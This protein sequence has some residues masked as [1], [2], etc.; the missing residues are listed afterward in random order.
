MRFKIIMKKL[1]NQKKNFII[2]II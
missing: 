1:S 2:L